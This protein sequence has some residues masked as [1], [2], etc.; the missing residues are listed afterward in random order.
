M[1]GSEMPNEVCAFLSWFV[2]ESQRPGIAVIDDGDAFQSAA[3]S[4]EQFA[5]RWL[6]HQQFFA[7]GDLDLLIAGDSPQSFTGTFTDFRGLI[8]DQPATLGSFE[9]RSREGMFRVAL[10]AG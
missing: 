9:N 10:D 4:G 5:R 6:L 2:P 1:L 7:T 8:Q 3:D